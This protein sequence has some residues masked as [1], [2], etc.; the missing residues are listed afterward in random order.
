MQVHTGAQRSLLS[1]ALQ[2]F[3][4]ALQYRELILV[5]LGRELYQ[6]FRASYFGWVW[7]VAAPLL[8]LYV[9]VTLFSQTLKV[10]SGIEV[11]F[12]LGM[13]IGLIFFNAFAELITRAP[14]LLSEHVN[15]IKKSIFPSEVLAWTSALR[16]LTYAG[17]SFCV[18]L[19]FEIYIL[20]GIP[21]TALMFP[22]L[23][24]PFI[25][26]LLGWTWLL[27][28]LGAFTR[29][30]SFMIAT[31]TPVLIFATPVFYSI[32]NVPFRERLLS[33][34]NPVAPYIEM[35]R[36]I[37]LL[38]QPFDLPTYGIA[39]AFSL[40]IFYFGYYF[41]MRFRSITVDVI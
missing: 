14:M 41:F 29:D 23:L 3:F 16:S 12:A 40:F 25:M 38:G 26:M 4:N 30:V 21:W 8:M 22:L 33:L 1:H 2:P 19:L 27:A 36:E 17:I 32:Q 5:I 18:F 10:Q 13:F 34:L 20:G 39:W 6:R 37:F 9:F 15:F 24:P 28:A 31:I 35:A 7:S 11:N